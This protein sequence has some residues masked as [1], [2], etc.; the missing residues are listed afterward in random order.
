MAGWHGGGVAC[1]YARPV[2]DPWTFAGS[3]ATLDTGGGIVT[4]VDESTFAISS[5]SGDIIP[6][7]PQGLFVRDTRVISRFE[8]RIDGRRLEAAGNDQSRP[9]QRGLRRSGCRR[10]PARRL[11]PDGVPLALRGAGDA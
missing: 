8:L 9:V 6:G 1:R 11:Q 4:L 5:R 2:A 3:S 7:G 10:P